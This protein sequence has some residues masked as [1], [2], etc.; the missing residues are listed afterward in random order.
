MLSSLVFSTTYQCPISCRYCGAEC[1]P[2]HT[3]RLSLEDMIKIV[4]DVYSYGKLGLVVF[5]GGEPFL[6]G[7]DLLKC[8]EYCAKKNLFTRIVTNAFW[9]KTADVAKETIKRYK[10]A[11]LKEIN[12]SCDDYHQ[13]FIPLERIKY[14]ND[15]CTEVCLPCLIGHKIMKNCTISIEHLETFLGCKLAL[16]DPE[17]KNPNNN[18]VSTGY[19]VPIAEDMHLIPDEEILYPPTANHWKAPCSSILNR[20][21]ITPRKEISICCGMVPRKVEEIVFGNLDEHSLEELIIM[22]H[23]DL[24]VNWLALEGPYG[25][26]KFILKKNP[27]IPFR[28]QYVNNCHLCSEIL[29]REDCRAVLSEFGHEKVMEISLERCL[30]DHV[31]TSEEI[32][33]MK[34]KARVT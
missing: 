7:D 19:T 27:N 5:T 23:K 29:T 3:E 30:Y 20:V 8:V 31:R 11:G 16:Y 21:V 15:A 2:E 18:L 24:I 28:K 6:L 4:D 10:E 1:G 17:K 32:M 33:A 12:L 26:M 14:A 25:L 13:E 34:V 22:A 9:A